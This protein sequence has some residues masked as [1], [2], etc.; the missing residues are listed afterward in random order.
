MDAYGA[1][2]LQHPEYIALTV[3]ALLVLAGGLLLGRR[4]RRQRRLLAVLH[5]ELDAAHRCL[6][7]LTPVAPEK[8]SFATSLDL[9]RQKNY[10]PA[11]A[12]T[13]PLADKYRQ[14]AALVARG[15]AAADIAAALN[16]SPHEAEQLSSLA[17]V[18]R[19]APKNSKEKSP[20]DRNT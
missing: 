9:A 8:T 15:V 18:A 1:T 7:N 10:P 2:M 19:S 14:A 5:Q 16:I 20:D 12:V 13:D 4:L 11:P 17:R 6:D 3:L